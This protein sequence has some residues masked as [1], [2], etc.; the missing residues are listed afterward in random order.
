MVVVVVVCGDDGSGRGTVVET[1][2]SYKLEVSTS[3][4][5]RE[6][7]TLLVLHK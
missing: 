6:W 7:Q 2:G 1:E 4:V 3:K 5:A